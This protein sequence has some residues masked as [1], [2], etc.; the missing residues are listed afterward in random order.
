MISRAMPPRRERRRS[1]HHRSSEEPEKG[2]HL[3][4]HILSRKSPNQR[5]QGGAW[6]P[7]TPPLKVFTRS[8]AKCRPDD[9][10]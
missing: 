9:E 8:S 6:H 7:K 2:F 1:R 3:E 10:E 5:L 4:K